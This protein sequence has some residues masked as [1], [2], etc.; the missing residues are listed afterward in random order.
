MNKCNF[1]L[2]YINI[3]EKSVSSTHYRVTADSEMAASLH[4][5]IGFQLRCPCC[6]VQVLDTYGLFLREYCKNLQNFVT[7]SSVNL[8]DDESYATSSID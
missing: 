8:K 3:L 7:L 5:L 2:K 6:Q 4:E 1:F